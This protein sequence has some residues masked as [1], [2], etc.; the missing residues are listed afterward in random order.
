M[1]RHLNES[2]YHSAGFLP[3]IFKGREYVGSLYIEGNMKNGHTFDGRVLVLNSQ[4]EIISDQFDGDV[5]ILTVTNNDYRDD[6]KIPGGSSE[7]D[8]NPY[9]TLVREMFDEA[10][11]SVQKAVQF[12]K[13]MYG[14]HSRNF[15]VV[16]GIIDLG[17]DQIRFSNNG[18]EKLKI[19][20]MNI[21]DFSCCLFKNQRGAFKQLVRIL[22][23]N[24]MFLNK[25]RVLVETPFVERI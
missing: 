15:F 14:E 24:E 4:G 17:F 25:Y 21:V 22:S 11:C 12:R 10:F 18:R 2:L 23:K 8:E 19:Y 9:D 1:K 5:C 3:A 16:D 6:C 7:N 20:W 13:E